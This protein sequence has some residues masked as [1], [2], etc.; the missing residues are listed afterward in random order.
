MEN[1]SPPSVGLGTLLRALVAQL[2]PQVETA[3][4]NEV[5]EMRSRYF[6]VMRELLIRE[7]VGVSEL[8]ALI[9]VSQPAMSQTIAE[10]EKAGFVTRHEAVDRRARRVSLS[11]YGIAAAERLRP[12]WDSVER[13]VD[14]LES[15]VGVPLREA[16]ADLIGALAAKDFQ[17]RIK[18]AGNA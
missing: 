18:E 7:E 2:E 4:Q 6:P 14:T 13:A 1:D 15:E 3:Y 10:M 5:P 11:P 8:S 17:T 9:H 16:L 12:V